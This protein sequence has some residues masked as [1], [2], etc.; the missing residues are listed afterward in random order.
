MLVHIGT[1]CFALL[2]MTQ[3]ERNKFEL[4]EKIQVR[5]KGRSPAAKNK[6]SRI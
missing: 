3:K 2:L 4:A 5:D 1:G 6:E